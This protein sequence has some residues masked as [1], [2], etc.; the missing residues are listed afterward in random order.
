MP[1]LSKKIS[2]LIKFTRVKDWL[3]FLFLPLLDFAPGEINWFNLVLAVFCAG[4]CLAFAYGYN[5]FKDESIDRNTEQF[6][7]DMYG[8]TPNGLRIVLI[9]LI[10]LAALCGVLIDPMAL[11]AAIVS[12]LGSAFYSGGPRLKRIPVIGTLTNLM[13]FVPLTLLGGSFGGG[14]Y[15]I[16]FLLAL[17]ALLM[18]SQ[19][20]HEAA[21][22]KEDMQ[23]MV[24]TT[25]VKFGLNFSKKG[26]LVWGLLSL[27]AFAVLALQLDNYWIWIGTGFLA[28]FNLAYMMLADFHNEKSTARLRLEHRY[29]GLLVGTIAY[30]TYFFNG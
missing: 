1:K 8:Y 25:A 4:F 2:K 24:S 12:I 29:I 3:H 23:Q 10:F 7:L 18:Q 21:D 26:S 13:I 28:A 16:I 27:I 19:M 30:I 22:Y 15:F 14:F 6:S 9:V 11:N 5:Q 20:I 17:I